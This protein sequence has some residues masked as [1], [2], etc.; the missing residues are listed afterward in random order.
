MK[1]FGNIRAVFILVLILGIAF[2]WYAKK[3][4]DDL[5]AYGKAFTPPVWTE[6][7]FLELQKCIGKTSSVKHHQI[8][9][10]HID[11]K[12][13]RQL[14]GG[15]RE[16][17]GAWER[18]SGTIYVSTQYMHDSLLIRHELGHVVMHP[19][20]NHPEV[21]FNSRCGTNTY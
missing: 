1:L 2:V 18:Q 4:T 9:W 20:G 17:V 15:W 5:G 10:R 14:S 7:V 13:P 6:E 3:N 11:G 12:I 16:S 21:A 19:E 8:S